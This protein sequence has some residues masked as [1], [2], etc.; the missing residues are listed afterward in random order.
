VKKYKK[1]CE[2][3]IHLRRSSSGGRQ[4]LWKVFVFIRSTTRSRNRLRRRFLRLA[5]HRIAREAV[6]RRRGDLRAGLGHTLAKAGRGHDA[7]HRD[8]ARSRVAV[9][10]E[11]VLSVFWRSGGLADRT[12]EADSIH[13][14][15]HAFDVLSGGAHLKTLLLEL[16]ETKLLSGLTLGDLDVFVDLLARSLPRTLVRLHDEKQ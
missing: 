12:I 6:G 1:G 9:G 15:G 4:I 16:Q 5:I 2:G 7:V 13:A 3:K 14:R 10:A 11:A 8:S